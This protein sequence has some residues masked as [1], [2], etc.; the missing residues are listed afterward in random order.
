MSKRLLKE[1]LRQ[2]ESLANSETLE[3]KARFGI[4]TAS[5]LG[6]TMPQIRLV[7]VPLG[8]DQ[9]LAEQLW[10]TGVH[11]AR[12]LAAL[13]GDPDEIASI[14]MDRWSADFDSW[15]V[16]DTCCCELF[17]RTPLAWV[18]I[19]KWAAHN[20]EF[21]RRAGFATLAAIAA[22]NKSLGDDP[23][24]EALPLIEQY[25][26]DDRPYARKGVNWAL[27]NIGK[28][29]VRLG[30]AAIACAERIRNQ[31]SKAAR[32]I[33]ADALRELRRKY[34]PGPQ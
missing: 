26:F 23:F 27:R 20:R 16:C 34:D 9:A 32:W 3:G 1:V 25:A 2:M 10:G 15:D 33:A 28:R 30:E 8:K 11:E 14:T 31:D 21:V 19:R 5:A 13:I 29:N 12:I 6:L 24:L 22:H 18:K 7:A 17:D 4:K